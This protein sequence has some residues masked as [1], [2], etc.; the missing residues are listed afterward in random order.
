MNPIYNMTLTELREY[1]DEELRQLLAYMEQERQSG[2]AHGNPYRASCTYWMCV[3]ER[4]IRKGSPI[5]EHMDIKCIHNIFDTG[6]KYIF[7]RGNRYHM[8]QFDDTLLVFNDKREPYLFSKSEDDAKC[9][10][11]YFDLATGQSSQ[12][13]YH[14]TGVHA[15]AYGLPHYFYNASSFRCS[16]GH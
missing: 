11:K 3:L 16:K 7:R 14:F 2:V 5:L 15:S 1:T 12:D 10:W 8:Y 9:I 6:Q 13:P 4:Q